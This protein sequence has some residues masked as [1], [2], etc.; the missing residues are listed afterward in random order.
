MT[1]LPEPPEATDRAEPQ[2][3]RRRGLQLLVV[4]AIAAVLAVT[5]AVIAFG[6]SHRRLHSA[7]AEIRP[8]PTSSAPASP[9]TPA[10]TSTAPV[11]R[12]SASK[13]PAAHK[14]ARTAA[15]TAGPATPARSTAGAGPAAGWPQQVTSSATP[16]AVLPSSK[17][18]PPPKPRPTHTATPTPTEPAFVPHF[19]AAPEP[20][21]FSGIPRGGAAQSLAEQCAQN[22]SCGVTGVE[23]GGSCNLPGYR[24]DTAGAA[25]SGWAIWERAPGDCTWAEAVS[26]F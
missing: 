20:A 10:P 1:A 18:V 14:P 12:P 5:V 23:W 24:G 19:L 25:H 17:P 11:A 13:R 6:H 15:A 8:A 7:A 22:G 4:A 16:A 2:H 3:S 9:T 26:S 21:A